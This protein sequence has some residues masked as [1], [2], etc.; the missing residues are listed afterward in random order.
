MKPE[1][2]I[3]TAEVGGRTLSFESGKLAHQAGGAVTVR[4]DDAMV[5]TRIIY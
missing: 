5:A 2:K 1:V 3:Y 4:L